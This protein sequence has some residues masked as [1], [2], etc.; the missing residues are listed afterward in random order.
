LPYVLITPARNEEAFLGDTIQGVL[1]QTVP[2]ARWV[3]VDDRS[4]DRTAEIVKGFLPAHPFMR[5]LSLSGDVSR[6][7]GKKASAFNAGIELLEGIEYSFLGNLD[8]DM[9]LPPGYYESVLGEFERDPS[10]GVGGGTVFTLAGGMPVRLDAAADS[11]PGAV[12]LFRKE[13]FRDIGGKYLLLEQ[14]GID[15]AAEVMARMRGWSV[16]QLPGVAAQEQRRMG[17]AADG[18]LAA[19]Y[20]EGTRFHSLGYGTLYYL[21]RAVYKMRFKPRVIGSLVAVAGFLVA[22][23]TAQPISLPSEVV[24]YLQA[25]QKL[26]LRALASGLFRGNWRFGV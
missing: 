9:K 18:D 12:Q 13:C 17:T 21:V 7:F 8:A 10:L 24:A 16:R 23:F 6:S 5:L 1:S 14:G 2:P 3:I 26:K 11:V 20:K 22:R 25:E 4:T 15:A 19:K